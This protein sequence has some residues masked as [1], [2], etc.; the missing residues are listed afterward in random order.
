ML[1]TKNLM[2]GS[3]SGVICSAGIY[4]N[5][6]MSGARIKT[7]NYIEYPDRAKRIIPEK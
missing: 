2:S 5:G 3:S 6:I 7:F 1:K 4:P